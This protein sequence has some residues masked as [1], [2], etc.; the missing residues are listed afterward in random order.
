VLADAQ[1]VTAATRRAE[2]L[3]ERVLADDLDTLGG[4]FVFPQIRETYY[5]VEAHVLLGDSSPQL[6]SRAEGAVRGFSD[7]NDPYWAFGDEAG[8]KS[9]LALARLQ[10][11]DL[12]GAAEAVQPVLELP[13]AQRNAGIIGSVQ[14]VRNSLMRT[15][16]RDAATA[17]ELREEITTF[18]SHRPL[19]LPR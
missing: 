1:T 7:T 14:R 15:P 6:V 17:R 4:I 19:A 2:D 16:V 18:S 10:L 5:T 12:E 8:A 9:N 13:P 3:R 11:G